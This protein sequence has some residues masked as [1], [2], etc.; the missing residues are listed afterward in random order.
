MEIKE[1]MSKTDIFDTCC[2][3]VGASHI[4]SSVETI[5]HQLGFLLSTIE[6]VKTSRNIHDVI[7]IFLRH[8]NDSCSF[9]PPKYSERTVTVG[10]LLD[11]E[12]EGNVDVR[13]FGPRVALFNSEG[14]MYCLTDGKRDI[15]EGNLILS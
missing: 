9:L 15:T 1:E 13:I 5:K 14:T 8:I 3:R 11:N 10:K 7:N 4:F 2:H 6:Q 12:V